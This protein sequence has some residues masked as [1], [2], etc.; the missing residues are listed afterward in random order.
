M[1]GPNNA[2]VDPHTAA[3]FVVSSAALRIAWPIPPF[4]ASQLSTCV[5]GGWRVTLNH[6][7]KKKRRGD[8]EIPTPC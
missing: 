4:E 1:K 2:Q 6:P 5:D 7:M 8:P 3:C